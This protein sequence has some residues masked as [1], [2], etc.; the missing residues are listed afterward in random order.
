MSPPEIKVL[1]NA[2][3][4]ARDAA[5]RV[6]EIA[7]ASI[8]LHDRFS[9]ALSGG[10]TPKKLYEFLATDEF[11]GQIGWTKTEI[12]FGDERCVPP[13]DPESNYRMAR[14]AFLSKVPIPG[15]NVYRMRGE[16]DPQLAAIEYGL[17]L[18]EKFDD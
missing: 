13:D 17:M 6:V 11:R 8:E 10:S 9:I 15:D 18:K 1:P 5:N 12:F 2:D 4:I 14:E 7:E 3:A 16:I